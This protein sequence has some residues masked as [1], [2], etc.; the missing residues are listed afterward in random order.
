MMIRLGNEDQKREK[1]IK[2][3]YGMD[4]RGHD[5]ERKKNEMMDKKGGIRRGE[6][7]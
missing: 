2:R 4:R 3:K 1:E 7:R 6:K 5:M